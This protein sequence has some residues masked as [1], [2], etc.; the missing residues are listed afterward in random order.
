MFTA[1]PAIVAII[2]YLVA[3]IPSEN[4]LKAIKMVKGIIEI[5]IISK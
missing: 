4:C 5:A 1:F 3:D 2:A